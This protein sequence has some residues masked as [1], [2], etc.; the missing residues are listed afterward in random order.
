LHLTISIVNI[1]VVMAQPQ[2]T[3]R[4]YGGVSAPERVADRRARFVDAAVELY[5]TRGYTATR[6][7]E[8]CR[9][10]G[11]TDRYFYES[12]RNQAELFAAAFQHVVGHLLGAVAAAVTAVPTEPAAQ[13]RAAIETFVRTLA[14]DRRLARLLFVE[15]TSVSGGVEREVR[16]SIRRFADLIAATARPHVPDV[17]DQLVTMGALSLVGAIQYVLTEWLDGDLDA[18]VDEMI[19]YFVELLLVAGTARERVS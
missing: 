4:S 6:V 13:A 15:A 9:A 7:K 18:T 17:P 2:V 8:L 14:D 3:G 11:L 1:V 12:F 5:G 10:A 16:A 19:D